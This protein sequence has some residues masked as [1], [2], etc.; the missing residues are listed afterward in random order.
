[1]KESS[2]VEIIQNEE[3]EV[4]DTSVFIS[5]EQSLHEEVIQSFYE[6][7]DE[8]FIQVSEKSSLDNLVVNDRSVSF[9][10]QELSEV[11]PRMTDECD[12]KHDNLV[13]MSYEGQEGVSEASS[14][15]ENGGSIEIR[16][17]D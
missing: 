16:F 14:T 2:V 3:N 9:E 7:Q 10:F 5:L 8:I 17:I 4:I 13:S 12:K 15:F 6:K 1:M 11:F